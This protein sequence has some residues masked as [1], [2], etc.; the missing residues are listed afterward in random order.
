MRYPLAQ[1][2]RLTILC[3]NEYIYIYIYILEFNNC[4]NNNMFLAT[5]TRDGV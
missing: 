5:I 4:N 3:H 2:Y 1:Q